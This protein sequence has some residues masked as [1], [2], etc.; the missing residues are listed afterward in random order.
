MN[1]DWLIPDW[2]APP[3]VKAVF[4]SRG[5]AETGFASRSGVSQPPFDAFNLGDHVG[6]DPTHV[7]ANRHMLQ[8]LI[9]AKPIYLKQVHGTEVATLQPKT[10]HGMVADACITVEKKLACTIMV[11]DCLPVIFTDLEGRFVAAAHAGWRGLADG[12][13]NQSV[14]FILE[15]KTTVAGVFYNFSAI[16]IIAWLGPCIGPAAFEVGSEVKAAFA[17]KLPNSAAYFKSIVDPNSGKSG[18]KYLADLAG[19]ARLN[20]QQLGIAAA[21]IYGNDG[22]T[23]WCT[24]SNPSRYFSHRR[25]AVRLGGSGRMAGCIWIE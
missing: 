18:T 14:S 12:V 16:N 6:D 20:L 17:E 21:N 24:V 25:D 8:T 9:G 22:S 3:H 10:S 5:I 7:M 13:L 23:D 15:V 2:P 4:T 11:A 1:P 19:L